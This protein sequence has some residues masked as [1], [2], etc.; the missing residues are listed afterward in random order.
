MAQFSISGR[1]TVKTLKSQFASTYGLELRVY[2]GNNFADENA[3]LASISSK[4]VDD[5]ECKSNMLVGN[6][7]GRFKESTGLK[8]Q[9]ATLPNART[10]PGVLVNDKFSLSEASAKFKP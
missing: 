6:F 1:M 8:V 4:K 2:K 10:E 7:E 5:F 3:T 9:I